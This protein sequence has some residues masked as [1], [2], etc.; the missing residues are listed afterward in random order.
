LINCY[1]SRTR[2]QRCGPVG[3]CCRDDGSHIGDP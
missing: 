3:G 1:G 2:T